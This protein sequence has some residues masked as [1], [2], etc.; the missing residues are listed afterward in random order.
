MRIP[1]VKIRNEK[2]G[3]T[4]K[5]NAVD[6]ATDLGR[7]RYAGWRLVSEQSGDK[8]EHPLIDGRPVGIPGKITQEEADVVDTATGP[9]RGY[10]ERVAAGR[11][12]RSRR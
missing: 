4:R 11:A 12:P 2:T 8:S 3:E 6:Y 7:S 9:S 5:I 10:Q 1:T